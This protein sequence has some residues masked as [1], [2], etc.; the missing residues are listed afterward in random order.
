[1]QGEESPEALMRRY[2]GGD[3]AAFDALFVRVGPRVFRFLLAMTHDRARAEDL[4]QTTF[5]NFHR[6]RAGWLPGAPVLPWLMAI[7]RNA[8]RDDARRR[9]TAVVRL[10]SDGELPD[11]AGDDDLA[12]LASREAEDDARLKALAGALANLAPNLREAL[13]L[14]RQGG[15]SHREAA[16]VLG[17]TETAVKLRV[18]RAYVKLRAVLRGAPGADDRG[19]S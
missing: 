17:T 13:A 14:T 3:V 16:A 2:L 4:F 12:Q 10:T 5:L 19:E 8:L 11:L 15:L 9:A 1:M 6:A 7:A 18:H